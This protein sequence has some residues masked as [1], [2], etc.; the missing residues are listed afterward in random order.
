MGN[1]GKLGGVARLRTFDLKQ[2]ASLPIPVRLLML[3]LFCVATMLFFVGV[4]AQPG[5]GVAFDPAFRQILEAQGTGDY[6]VVLREQADLGPAYGI[7]DWDERGR[8]VVDALRSNAAKSQPPL[9]RLLSSRQ[10]T[11]D[12][13]SVRS[14]TIV[15]GFL[16]T[17]G[18]ATF[19]LLAGQKG[20]ERLEMDRL[21][22][23]PDPSLWA[24]QSSQPSTYAEWGVTQIGADAIWRDFGVRGEGVV[25]ANIDSG[26]DYLHPALVENYRGNLGDGLF[27]HGHSWFDPFLPATVEPVPYDTHGTHTMGTLVGNGGPDNQIGV[28]PGSRWIAATGS[29]SIGAALLSAEWLLA[30]YTVAGGPTQGDPDLRPHVISNS[31]NIISGGDRT[32]AQAIR[33]WRAAGIV[34]VFSAGNYGYS[35]RTISSPA[36]D[37]NVLA[38]GATNAQDLIASFSGRGPG[39]IAECPDKPDFVAPGVAIRSSIPGGYE[40]ME[41]TSMAAPHVAGCVALL[42]SLRPELTFDQIY[43]LFQQSAVDLGAPG[44]DGRYGY[45]R[46]DCYRAAAALTFLHVTPDRIDICTDSAP[47]IFTARVVEPIENPP[48]VTLAVVGAPDGT[49]ISFGNNPVTPTNSALVTTELSVSPRTDVQP[50]VYPLFVVGSTADRVHTSTV[51][52]GI[53]SG[54]PTAPL[55]YSPAHNSVNVG[56]LPSFRWSGS[57]ATDYLF[58]ISTDPTFASVV[59]SRTVSA[60]THKMTDLLAFDTTYFWRVTPINP[61]GEGTASLVQSFVAETSILHVDSSASG[62]GTG[63]SWGDAFHGVND[64]LSIAQVGSEIW[65]AAGRYLPGSDPTDTFLIADGVRLFGGFQ[66]GEDARDERL[67]DPAVNN[68]VLD[69]GGIANHVVSGY[70][71]GTTTVVDGFMITGGNAVSQ[72]ITGAPAGGGLFFVRSSP[73]LRNLAIVGNR[74]LGYGGGARLVNSAPY[75]ERVTFADNHATDGGG[76]HCTCSGAVI[77][78]LT[79]L[80]NQADYVGGGMVLLGD[81]VT[82][83]NALIAGNWAYMGGGAS[84]QNVSLSN[85]AVVG[86]QANTQGGGLWSIGSSPHLTQVTLAGNRAGTGGSGIYHNG[87]SYLPSYRLANSIFWQNGGTQFWIEGRGGVQIESSL[88][89]GGCPTKAICSGNVVTTNPRLVRNPASGADGAWGTAD[90]DYGGLTLLAN[91]PA[92]DAG[93]N[94]AVPADLVDL[95]QDGDI[96]EVLPFDLAGAVRFVDVPAAD[97][98]SGDPPIVD[99]GAYEADFSSQNTPTPTVIPTVMSTATVTPTSSPTPTSTPI[100]TPTTTPTPERTEISLYLPQIIVNTRSDR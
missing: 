37:C 56:R 60:D 3:G 76:L 28:A 53:Y 94:S 43:D 100:P 88:I 74:A 89:V 22:P 44:Y 86:N 71:A 6:I 66:G 46:I 41:G 70:Y 45:G 73:Q 52:V 68:T 79:L 61:C 51:S 42:L 36:D 85:A 93:A 24:T 59:Y 12:V 4:N 63:A 47:A 77:R 64:A 7:D 34:P 50:G 40:S 84:L 38:V 15:N 55:L 58:Q 8:F 57:F 39:M 21:I 67:V 33:A 30:P 99:L 32:Y 35:D 18:L 11:G 1:W 62:Q 10:A 29:T 96:G 91:S 75:L 27:S 78:D 20:V 14:L 95:D 80:R 19:D 83:V 25:V 65:V 81:D 54:V 13:T 23:Q 48:A 82:V 9:Y 97:T 31:W 92:L 5:P 90:D 87:Y 26:V 16:V 72:T 49:D 17:S 69:G 98:G 2:E